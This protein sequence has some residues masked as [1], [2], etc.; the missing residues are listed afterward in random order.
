MRM[1]FKDKVTHLHVSRD[2]QTECVCKNVTEDI[3]SDFG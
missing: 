1:A 2:Q 3:F